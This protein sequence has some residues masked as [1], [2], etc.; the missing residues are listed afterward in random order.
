MTLKELVYLPGHPEHAG[1]GYDPES[2]VVTYISL[3]PQCRC[4][5]HTDH[6]LCTV[7]LCSCSSSQDVAGACHQ[8]TMMTMPSHILKR[9]NKTVSGAEKG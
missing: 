6:T 7:D 4:I 3:E 9:Q 5:I 2:G 8:C 1:V